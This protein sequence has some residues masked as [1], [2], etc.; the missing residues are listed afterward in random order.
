M[1][2]KL[3]FLSC[4]FLVVVLM[5]IVDSSNGY[6][7]YVGGKDG[8]V[9]KPS[10]KYNHWAERMRFQVNDTLYFRYEKGSDSV[11]V[12]SEADYDSCNKKNPIQSLANGDSIFKFDHS[13]P[14]FFISGHANNCEKGQR[15]IVV[16]MAVRNKTHHQEAPPSPSPSPAESPKGDTDH[17]ETP[18]YPPEFGS[19]D[20]P[21]P[22]P[23]PSSLSSGPMGSG[24]SVVSILGVS[25]VLGIFV[26]MF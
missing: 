26:G 22:A 2:S 4:L 11:L 15:L 1:E 7:F 18:V 9:V 6:K 20:V 5:S 12:V 10:E 24:W 17:P 3:W 16:V 25:A 14:F 21:A 19:V 8:W 23:A 13:G